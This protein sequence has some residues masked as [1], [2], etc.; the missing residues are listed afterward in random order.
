MNDPAETTIRST[1]ELVLPPQ[2]GRIWQRQRP[3][4]PHAY[5]HDLEPTTLPTH[6]L[7]HAAVS[8]KSK[9][10]HTTLELVTAN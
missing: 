6:C 9:T 3:S 2:N 10:D 7:P 1:V 4:P 5:H 8:A